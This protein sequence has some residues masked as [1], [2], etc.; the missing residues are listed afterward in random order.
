MARRWRTT[1]AAALAGAVTASAITAWCL[2]GDDGLRYADDYAAHEPLRVVGYPSTGSLRLTQEVVWRLA[3]GSRNGLAA[4]ATSDGSAAEAD[5]TAANWVRSFQQGAQGPVTAEFH[6]EGSVRQS[7]VLYFER[8]GQV[9]QLKL[10]LDGN[11]GAD[12]WRILLRE[13][14]P[15]EAAAPPTWAP[16]TPGGT[17][18]PGVR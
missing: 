15:Q 11:G 14:D 16:A 17:L 9:K 3:D 13:T 1:T 7:V 10:R 6:G 18:P 4:L 12:G 5:T 8:S 2:A